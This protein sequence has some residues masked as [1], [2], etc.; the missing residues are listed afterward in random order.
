MNRDQKLSLAARVVLC[1]LLAVVS[2]FILGRLLSSPETYSGILQSLKNSKMS[3]LPKIESQ[4][5][6]ISGIS[7]S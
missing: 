3:L 1:I 5:L 2:F 4:I 7:K 6:R